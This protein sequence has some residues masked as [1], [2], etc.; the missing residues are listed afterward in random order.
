MEFASRNYD[1]R[2]QAQARWSARQ[3]HCNAN[4]SASAVAHWQQTQAAASLCSAPSQWHSGQNDAPSESL[5]TESLIPLTGQAT[6]NIPTR[7]RPRTNRPGPARPRARYRPV[8]REI[9]VVN[10]GSSRYKFLS[11]LVTGKAI[12]EAGLTG[13]KLP[14]CLIGNQAEHP[15]RIWSRSSVLFQA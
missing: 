1:K 8:S 12:G 4:A 13:K 10:T 9:S 14:I 2:C 5:P 6:D 15:S 11:F 7:P 3:L